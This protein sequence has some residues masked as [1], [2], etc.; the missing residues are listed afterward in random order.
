M[1]TLQGK[2][3]AL[4]GAGSGIGRALALNLAGRGSLLA[5]S[6]VDPEGLEETVA[7]LPAGAKATR[8]IVDVEA[9]VTKIAS[10][11]VPGDVVVVMS[12]GGFE[13]MHERL[14][15]ALAARAVA[16]SRVSS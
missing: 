12:N 11:A 9:M 14:L 16:S 2:V 1:K 8:H 3:V 4:T 7:M 10:E 5:L 6:D 13:R 15:E